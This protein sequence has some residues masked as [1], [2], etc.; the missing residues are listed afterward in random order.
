MA[1]RVNSLSLS[2]YRRMKKKVSSRGGSSAAARRD[3]FFFFKEWVLLSHSLV[4]AVS[5]G[6]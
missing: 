2:N 6:C 3:L 4:I 1:N 5:I